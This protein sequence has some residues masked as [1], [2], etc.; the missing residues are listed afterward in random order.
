MQANVAKGHKKVQ[1]Q[2]IETIGTPVDE[3]WFLVISR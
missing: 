2:L 3:A 1:I